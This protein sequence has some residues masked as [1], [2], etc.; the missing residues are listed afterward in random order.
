[1]LRRRSLTILLV[2]T[3]LFGAPLDALSQ[4][5]PAAP[6]G[7]EPADAAFRQGNALYKQQKYAEAKAAYEE[8]FRLKKSHDIASNLAYAE[9]KLGQSRDAAEHLAFAVKNWAPTGKA[10]NRE[11]ALHWLEVAKAAVTTLR[12]T[13]SVEGARVFVDGKLVGMSPLG[14]EVFVEP[15]ARTI[16][17]KLAGYQDVRQVVQGEKGGEQA[18]ALTLMAVAPPVVPAAPTPSSGPSTRVLIA[19]GSVAGAALVAGIAFMV[20]R[21]SKGTEATT[22]LGQLVNHGGPSV[23]DAQSV[24]AACGTLHDTLKARATLGDLGV[25]SLLVVGAAGAAT[26][27]YGLAAPRAVRT[28]QLRAAPIVS[29]QGGGLS[30]Q[31]SW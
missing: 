19:G 9:L 18:V 23:C 26:L 20:V 14:S 25:T 4:T 17:A 15:G 10:E 28:A 30:L 11:S 22:Q 5:P 13:V 29:A 27:I 21:G 3:A 2:V 16:E 7:T 1:M 6:S 8:A 24:P 31:G 12:V